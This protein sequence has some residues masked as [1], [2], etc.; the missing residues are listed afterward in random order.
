[1]AAITG[2]T[3]QSTQGQ[4][5]TQLL[6]RNFAT[7]VLD[8]ENKTPLQIAL[9]YQAPAWLISRLGGPLVSEAD[10]RYINW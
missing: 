5:V 1:M 7:D 3:P 4:I 10:F 8:F 6:D 9:R 2:A